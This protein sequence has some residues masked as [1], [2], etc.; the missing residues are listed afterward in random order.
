MNPE[1]SFFTQLQSFVDEMIRVFPEKRKV[2]EEYLIYQQSKENKKFIKEFHFLLSKYKVQLM[3]CD[4]S[5]FVSHPESK[6]NTLYLLRGIDFIELWNTVGIT[7]SIKKSIWEYLQLLYIIAELMVNQKLSTEIAEKLKEELAGDKPTENTENSGDMLKNMMGMMSAA[8]GMAIDVSKIKEASSTIKNL[9]QDEGD[10]TIAEIVEDVQKTL[11]KSV[12]KSG[13]ISI[14]NL[15][16]KD[17]DLFKSLDGIKDKLDSK[18]E[19]GEISEEKINKSMQKMMGKFTKGTPLE[20]INIEDMMKNVN[21]QDMMQSM[22]GAGSGG[23][24]NLFD[25][26]MMASVEKMMKSLPKK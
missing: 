21:I 23:M 22:A 11:E 13:K 1:T 5:I 10:T 20:G 6:M 3:N 12:D 16:N 19:K 4:E 7:A 14:M 24:P 26:K 15:L 17:S 18:L 2:F 25:P 9:L 8:D